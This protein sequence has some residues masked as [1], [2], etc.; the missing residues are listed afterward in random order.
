[1]SRIGKQ[2]VS[3]P[4]GVT[5]SVD[6]GTVSVQGPKGNLSYETRPEV[7]VTVNQESNEVVVTRHNDE[8][9]SR[10]Y[11]GLT[12]AL[13]NNMV[14]GVKDGWLRDVASFVS[15]DAPAAGPGAGA[16]LQNSGI[17]TLRCKRVTIANRPE[18]DYSPPAAAHPFRGRSLTKFAARSLV[19]VRLE[20]NV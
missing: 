4:A 18:H 6:G 17:L 14:T 19:A 8:R 5:V 1:M 2:P 12:R 11:H 20:S 3:I 10:A 7:A 15:P 13:I 9:A 16:H